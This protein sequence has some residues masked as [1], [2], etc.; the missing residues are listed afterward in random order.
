VLGGL[1]EAIVDTLDT[2]R[3]LTNTLGI[4]IF[5]LAIG[6]FVAIIF[7]GPKGYDVISG[8]TFTLLDNDQLYICQINRSEIDL[9]I[10]C[11]EAAE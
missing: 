3:S 7:L 8:D 1:M 4:I 9:I 5:L 2:Y 10:S 11:L 6:L